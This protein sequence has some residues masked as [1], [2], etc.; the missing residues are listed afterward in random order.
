[1]SL[2]GRGV[3]LPNQM[4]PYL[5][6]PLSETVPPACLKPNLGTRPVSES[7]C[8]V[9]AVAAVQPATATEAQ[10]EAETE[11]AAAAEATN[12]EATGDSRLRYA[13]S[14]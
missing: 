10:L 3:G 12:A 2:V 13:A 4:P 11:A 5:H 7:D 8:M 9:V 14:N 6:F 1:M